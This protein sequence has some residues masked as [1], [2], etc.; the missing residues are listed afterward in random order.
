MDPSNKIEVNILASFGT[1]IE[2]D[3]ISAT[4]AFKTVVCMKCVKSKHVH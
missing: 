2:T 3:L 4:Y 1:K